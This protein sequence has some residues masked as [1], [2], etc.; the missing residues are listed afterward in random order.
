MD[1]IFPLVFLIAILAAPLLGADS[2]FHDARGWWPGS[3]RR[4]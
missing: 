1:L 3:A 4:R 2:R